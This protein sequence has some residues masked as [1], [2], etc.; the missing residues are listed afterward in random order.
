[1]KCKAVWTW[2][3]VTQALQEMNPHSPICVKRSFSEPD[4]SACEV[5]CLL[6]V[7]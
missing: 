7:L 2:V 6:R 1:M 5:H 4:P 3:A